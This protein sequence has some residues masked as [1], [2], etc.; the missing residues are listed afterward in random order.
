MSGKKPAKPIAGQSR[1]QIQDPAVYGSVVK[2][3]GSKGSPCKCH[4]CGK[5]TVRGV[6]RQKADLMFCSASCAK[7]H[8]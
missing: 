8:N 7:S 5:E 6:M 2:Y 1:Q 3:I 4:K